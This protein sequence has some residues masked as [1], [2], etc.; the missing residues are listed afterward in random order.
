MARP[1]AFRYFFSWSRLDNSCCLHTRKVGSQRAACTHSK[2]KQRSNLCA[3]FSLSKFISFTSSLSHY[4][5]ISTHRGHRMGSGPSART[6][7]L[8]HSYQT[9]VWTRPLVRSTLAQ[10]DLCLLSGRQTEYL[11]NSS[12]LHYYLTYIQVCSLNIAGLIAL[13][14]TPSPWGSVC[15]CVRVFVH[16][17][18]ICSSCFA[19]SSAI[20][21]S[22]TS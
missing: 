2:V 7:S 12:A 19:C 22:V 9:L 14:I 6:H 15:V 8:D 1:R 13:Q 17:F 10:Q 18:S 3:S 21:I 16:Y 20:S 11:R 5:V 4:F